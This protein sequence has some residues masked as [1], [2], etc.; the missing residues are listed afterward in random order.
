MAMTRGQR[1]LLG[2]ALLALLGTAGYFAGWHVWGLYHWRAAQQAME[3]RA[4]QDAEDHLQRAMRARPRDWSVRLLA[5]QAARRHGNM[6][7]AVPN[8]RL[9]ERDPTLADDVALEF[10]LWPV[11]NGNLGE[12]S[13]LRRRAAEQPDA[14]AT[15]LILEALIE[16]YLKVL[17]AH[18]AMGFST[19]EVAQQPEL[20]WA[21]QAVAE[22][23]RTRPRQADQVQGLVWRGQLSY[24]ANEHADAIADLR[25]AVELDPDSFAARWHLAMSIGQELP[26]E[27][28]DHLA[29]LLRGRP[30]DK[31]LRLM[32]A[33][34]HRGAGRLEEARHLL[35]ELL[36][37]APEDVPVL[38]SR[39]RLALDFEQPAEA[40]RYLRRAEAIAPDSPDLNR[41]LARTL[42]LL[43]H[44]K[45]AEHYQQQFRQIDDRRKKRQEEAQANVKAMRQSMN[46]D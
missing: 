6:E 22:W 41:D 29:V 4:F 37:A 11:Q 40:E 3:R 44:P 28:A 5:A 38:V 13:A 9:C 31:K 43:G 14:A 17:I 8:L 24:I 35:D 46:H 45:E 36:D 30:N 33:L 1:R 15:P 39:A 34:G 32:L 7:L 42:Q 27:S 12:A 21:R 2:V 19:T 18:G 10:Q 23:L 16:G 26:A 20:V 25:K